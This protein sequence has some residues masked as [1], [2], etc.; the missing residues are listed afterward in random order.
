MSPR[1]VLVGI[2]V[3]GRSSRMGRAKGLIPAPQGVRELSEE[4]ASTGTLIERLLVISEQVVG[5]PT[6][7]VG[8]HAEYEGLGRPMVEDSMENAGPLGG[9]V[10]L[11]AEAERRG[12]SH[13]VA[14]ACDLPYL[15]GELLRRLVCSPAP[16]LVVCPR[17]EG[18]YQPLFA[19]YSVECAALARACLARNE[20][21]LQPIIKAFSTH[22]LDVDETEQVQLID[23]DTPEDI[24]A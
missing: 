8:R 6:V 21:G 22:V 3:G 14:L 18:K 17:S 9:L 5:C 7:L 19:R 24:Q 23:W 10:T 16:E 4:G 2:F 13:A 1:D 12:C 11:L 20:L 15:S